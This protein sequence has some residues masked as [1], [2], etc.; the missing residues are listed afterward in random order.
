MVA[1]LLKLL[2]II[3][4]YAHLISSPLVFAPV[5]TPGADLE[6]SVFGIAPRMSGSLRTEALL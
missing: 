6:D 5:E 3:L 2:A 1:V 4:R